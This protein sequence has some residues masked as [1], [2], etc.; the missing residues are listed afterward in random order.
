MATATLASIPGSGSPLELFRLLRG[1]TRFLRERFERHGRIFR[2]R[3]AYPVVFL[4][5]EEANKTVLVTRRNE[6]SF[7]LGYAQTA[8]K[9][10]FEG[11]IMLQDG[12]A[13]DR[14]RDVLSL[15][16]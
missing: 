8:V 10:V 2:S 9:R 7:G 6:L 4:V 14:T 12:E 15:A 13:H 1:A 5:G 11:S 16:V 3:L